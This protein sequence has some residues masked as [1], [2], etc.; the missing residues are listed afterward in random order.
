MKLATYKVTMRL[1]AGGRTVT[2]V[3]IGA[4]ASSAR[5]LDA[6]NIRRW[7][8]GEAPVRVAEQSGQRARAS[9]KKVRAAP[10]VRVSLAEQAAT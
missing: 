7:L 8:D 4:L 6:L 10:V 9:T 5:A 3:L 1:R 2:V